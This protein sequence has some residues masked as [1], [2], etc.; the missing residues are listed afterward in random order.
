MD[1]VIYLG[2]F[3][4]NSLISIASKSLVN[5]LLGQGYQQT[6]SSKIAMCTGNDLHNHSPL[7]IFSNVEY[8]SKQNSV[9][10]FDSFSSDIDVCSIVNFGTYVTNGKGKD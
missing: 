1:K 9:T 8:I 4:C 3:R 2:H 6:L 7:C 5:M 10:K